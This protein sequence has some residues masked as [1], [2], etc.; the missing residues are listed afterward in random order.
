MNRC[1]SILKKG[2]NSHPI[3]WGELLQAEQIVNDEYQLSL[4]LI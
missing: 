4:V 2:R 1:G 3:F